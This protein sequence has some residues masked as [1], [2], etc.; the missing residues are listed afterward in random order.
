[1]RRI[2]ASAVLTVFAAGPA[3][4]GGDAGAT[5]PPK[6][7]G[8][9]SRLSPDVGAGQSPGQAA[10]DRSSRR[11]RESFYAKPSKNPDQPG[12]AAS[13]GTAGTS[14]PRAPEPKPGG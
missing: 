8:G 12:T 7:T 6:P 13:D 2:L 10:H 9:A 14:S 5:N 11:T 3:M 1:M 4:A